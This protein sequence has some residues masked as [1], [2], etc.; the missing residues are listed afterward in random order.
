VLPP[1]VLVPSSGSVGEKLQKQSDTLQDESGIVPYTERTDELRD[2]WR[3][4]LTFANSM[5]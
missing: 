1:A 3:T 2:F 5:M 4:P